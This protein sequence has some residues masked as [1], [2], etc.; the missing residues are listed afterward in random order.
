VLFWER[1]GVDDP[2]G[3]ISVHAV[4]GLWGIL[5]VGLFADGTFGDGYNGV[6]GN[7]EGLFFG[8][9]SPRQLFAQ[10]IAAVSCIGWNVVIGGASFW[11][12]GKIIGGNRVTPE[13]EIAGLDVPEMGAPGYPEF[14]TQVSQEQITSSEIAAVKAKYGA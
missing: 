12:I 7:V 5:S 9:H 11:M 10:L 14:I 8:S 3:A 2:V 1:F 13:V 6:A 4:A